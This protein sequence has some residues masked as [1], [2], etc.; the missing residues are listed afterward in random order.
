MNTFVILFRQGPRSL[1]DTDKQRRSEEVAIWAR[2][3][4]E[5]GHKLAPHI[6]AP[7]SVKRGPDVPIAAH[8][9]WPVTALLL[10]EARDLDEAATVAES[11]PALRYGASVE[12][13]AWSRPPG[14][15]SPQVAQ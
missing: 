13:R 6:L 8:G 2:R 14:F 4:N 1:T 12:V 10:V 3:Q 15:V 9:E 7:E 5:A 11:H